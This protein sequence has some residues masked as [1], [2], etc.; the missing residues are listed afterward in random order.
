ML[1]KKHSG[2][3]AAFVA[4]AV[5]LQ[6][7]DPKPVDAFK[8]V[9]DAFRTHAIVAIGEAHRMQNPSDFVLALIRH[10][11]FPPAVTDI[12][13]EF[14]SSFH[15][16]LLDRYIAGETVSR[17][18]IRKVWRDTTVVN[19]IWEAPVY[20]HFLAGVRDRNLKVPRARRIRVLA[21]DPPIDWAKTTTIEQ[22]APFLARDRLWA[23]LVER[24]VLGKGR[25][26][27][28]FV[29]GSHVSRRTITGAPEK[30]V[31]AILETARPRSVFAVHVHDG[32]IKGNAELESRLSPWPIPSLALLADT[33]LGQ[34][35]AEPPRPPVRTRV[36]QGQNTPM[37]VVVTTPRLLSE[38]AD[39]FLYLGPR[40]SW[41][42]SVP[43]VESFDP[44]YLR[45][46]ERRHLL[47]F[48]RP[49]DLKELTR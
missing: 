46:L 16:P 26:A 34:T 28:L 25:K 33:W 35:K 5:C 24:E 38:K 30:N 48:G 3:A 49:L 23:D 47:I 6:A 20:E 19:G 11:D 45:E 7:Q 41:T 9:A 12:A 37:V 14:G 22:A 31:V 36:G 8:G 21:C 32:E 1:Q 39:A 2:A 13:I 29:G 18:E 10:P 15:Q 44:E 27:L 17:E 40:A 43:A 4:F 42:R